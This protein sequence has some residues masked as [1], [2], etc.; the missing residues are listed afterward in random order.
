MFLGDIAAGV[1]IKDAGKLRIVLL[2]F[3]G[4]GA[5]EGEGHGRVGGMGCGNADMEIAPRVGEAKREV[6]RVAREVLRRD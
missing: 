1:K 3:S 4:F 2:G 6:E 5:F